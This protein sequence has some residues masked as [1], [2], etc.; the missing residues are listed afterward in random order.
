MPRIITTAT[1][2]LTIFVL[3]LS[4][5]GVA[6]QTTAVGTQAES[7]LKVTDEILQ[8]VS[9]M[10]ELAIKKPVKSGLKT[11]EEIKQTVIKNMNEDD[12][13]EEVEVTQ[14]LLVKLGLIAKDFQLRDYTV[15]LLEEQIAGFYDPKTQEFF[16]A[17]WLPVNDQKTVIAHELVHALQDQH[18]NLRRFDKWPEGDSDAELAAHAVIEGDA[19]FA[20][21]QYEVQESGYRIS[22]EKVALLVKMAMQ[23]M[24]NAGDAQ[25]PVLAKAPAVLREALQFPY[26]SG[27]NFVAEILKSD[28]W[29]SVNDVHKKLPVSTE[30]IL[31]PERYLN[32]EQPVKIEVSDLSAALGKDWKRIDADVQG[33]F[34]FQ[35]MLGEFIRKGNANRA[36]DGWGGDRYVLYED[37]R[38]GNLLLA[39]FTSWD[40]I[41]DAKE[42][43]DAYA[44]R[45]EKRYGVRAVAEDDPEKP[46]WF[47][48]AEGLVAMQIREK[49][50]VIIEGAKDRAQMS[51]LLELMW[52]SKKG[53]R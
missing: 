51:R 36:A 21:F 39:T 13:P 32:G 6:P 43:F 17:A 5:V 23:N 7:A 10:R 20:M 11:K 25:Y 24:N 52:K 9:R 44:E 27:A 42:V 1:S 40:M 49:D 38:S 35:L 46:R 3:L 4:A 22:L 37:P 45:T 48:T 28:S 2:L 14:K 47:E 19:T 31:H 15:R 16:L 12:S 18:F 53:A 30:Q 34:G 26:T 8:T 41:G 29:K 50:V 33:E